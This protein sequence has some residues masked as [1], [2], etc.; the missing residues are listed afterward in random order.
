MKFTKECPTCLTTFD[1]TVSNKKYCTDK[2]SRIKWAEMRKIGTRSKYPNKYFKDKHCRWCSNL[3]SPV[4]PSNHYCNSECSKKG[5]KDMYYKRNYSI[6]Y[7]EYLTLLDKHDGGCWICG[8]SRREVPG[9]ILAVDHDHKTGEVR[10]VLCT[11]CNMAMGKLGDD[12]ES[13]K[14]VV[15]YLE[16]VV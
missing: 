4:G 3:F 15:K 16:G 7:R 1:T 14:K 11:D 9:I 6:G 12:L 8:V 5:Q 2:C 13:L 10:G